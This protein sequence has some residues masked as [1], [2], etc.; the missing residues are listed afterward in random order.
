MCDLTFGCTW[1]ESAACSVEGAGARLRWAENEEQKRLENWEGK[2][3]ELVA[4]EDSGT[5]GIAWRFFPC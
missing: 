1:L 4:Q 5:Y 2:S 3:S